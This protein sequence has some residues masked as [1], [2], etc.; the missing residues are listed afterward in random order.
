VLPLGRSKPFK[1]YQNSLSFLTPIFGNLPK[2]KLD[3]ELIRFSLRNLARI[4]IDIPH[5]PENP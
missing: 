2:R 1:K 4:L 5:I 3:I